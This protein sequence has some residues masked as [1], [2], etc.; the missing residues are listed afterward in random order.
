MSAAILAFPNSVGFARAN[1]GWR[2]GLAR[3]VK[4]EQP[5]F[6]GRATVYGCRD[7]AFDEAVTLSERL[8]LPIVGSGPV[9]D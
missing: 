5:A 6:T 4:G 1:D 8:H 7:E 2:V 3:W 9:F